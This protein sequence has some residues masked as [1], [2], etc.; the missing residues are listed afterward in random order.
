MVYNEACRRRAELFGEV[1]EEHDEGYLE[2]DGGGIEDFSGAFE[3]LEEPEDSEFVPAEAVVPE[4]QP[5]A[6]APP[7]PQAP[8]LHEVEGPRLQPPTQGK[9]AYMRL[10]VGG[11]LAK[12][13]PA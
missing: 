5:L 1:G 2:E 7:A 10:L 12:P 9:L 11:L 8:A 6:T 4:A 3:E 13:P